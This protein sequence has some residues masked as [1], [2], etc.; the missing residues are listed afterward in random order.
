MALVSPFQSHVACRNLPLTGPHYRDSKF[1]TD[2][3]AGFAMSSFSVPS[4]EVLVRDLL[5][6]MRTS[7]L[8]SPAALIALCFDWIILLTELIFIEKKNN[9]TQT[10]FSLHRKRRS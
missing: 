2:V 5:E 4:L 6:R 3:T 1:K 10:M 7:P 9:N 8:L